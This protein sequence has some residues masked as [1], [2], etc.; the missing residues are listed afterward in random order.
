[1]FAG[2]VHDR[3]YLDKSSTIYSCI[4]RRSSRFLRTRRMSQTRLADQFQQSKNCIYVSSIMMLMTAL[5][6]YSTCVLI[7]VSVLW[8]VSAISPETIQLHINVFPDN[9]Y[10]PFQICTNRMIHTIYFQICNHL[11]H[12]V[13]DACFLVLDK[14]HIIRAVQLLNI[15]K[16]YGMLQTGIGSPSLYKIHN[17]TSPALQ[18]VCTGW[19]Y[20]T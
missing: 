14:A 3:T 10:I 15:L 7:A 13:I 18:Y 16:C 2:K 19:L 20:K 4:R 5:Q 11:V 9:I 6:M 12:C 17:T 8:P 1:M